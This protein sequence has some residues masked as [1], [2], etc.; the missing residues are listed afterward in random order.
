MDPDRRS[1]SIALKVSKSMRALVNTKIV[2]LNC[3]QRLNVPLPIMPPHLPD[4]SQPALEDLAARAMH[5]DDNWR[6]MQPRPTSTRT[7]PLDSTVTQMAMCQGT[8]FTTH[9]DGSLRCWRDIESPLSTRESSLHREDP[10]RF[11]T[12][13]PTS[14]IVQ[15]THLRVCA[16]S[17]RGGFILAYIGDGLDRRTHCGVFSIPVVSRHAPDSA[18]GCASDPQSLG[19]FD[20]SKGA[21]AISVSPTSVV[22]AGSGG[23]I[24]IIDI[25]SGE[26]H[27]AHVQVTPSHLC[28]GSDA[29]KILR[30]QVI[31]EDAFLVLTSQAAMVYA[32]PSLHTPSA[33]M[34]VF[35]HTIPKAS[36]AWIQPPS[37]SSRDSMV[38]LLTTKGTVLQFSM[39]QDKDTMTWS[40]VQ[41]LSRTELESA[42]HTPFPY[43]VDRLSLTDMHWGTK[44]SVWVHWERGVDGWPLRVLGSNGFNILSGE[45]PP[46]VSPPRI[47]FRS[48]T[49]S[50]T[51]DGESELSELV[52]M[53]TRSVSM[54]KI[55]F[56]EGIGRLVMA[57]LASP[58]LVLCEF[59]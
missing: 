58:S 21:V 41:S 7:I 10:R 44:R 17:L 29:I 23:A 9:K 47:E 18:V 42:E 32:I 45:A 13:T 54:P 48:L 16:D 24:N 59:A 11:V 22:V 36:S 3:L 52:E 51:V 19:H 49:S 55:C 25:A 20:E 33:G 53:C 15:F 43:P 57:G 1:L 46:N 4:L 35:V 5:L 27:S 8:L 34:P 6:S 40:V 30:L 38:T 37:P 56:D 2:W 26:R 50:E 12:I 31:S 28:H 14:R 39:T